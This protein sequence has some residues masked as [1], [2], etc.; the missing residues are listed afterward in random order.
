MANITMQ[1]DRCIIIGSGASAKGFV[2]P[3]GV[4][5]IAVNFAIK[6]HPTAK[7]WFSLDPRPVMKLLH[8]PLGNA[9]Y[10]LAHDGGFQIPNFVKQYKRI[11]KMQKGLQPKDKNSAE[12]WLW[13]SG[14]T[15]GLQVDPE[16]IS[17]GNS[18]YGALN[19]AYHL[20]YKKIA[21]VGIDG[22]AEPNIHTKSYYANGYKYL[23]EIFSSC[24]KQCIELG[25]EVVNLGEL[26]VFKKMSLREW[27]ND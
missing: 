3:K 11:G 15:L 17:N 24:E 18:G 1:N 4:D 19:L 13:W 10:H 27:L 23:N 14:A 16:K 5:V 7:H 9:T 22:N 6:D 2:P 25:L 8:K 20:G 26:K 12:W 21:L